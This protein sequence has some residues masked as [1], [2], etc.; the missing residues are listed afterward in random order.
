MASDTFFYSPN[1]LAA[2]FENKVR[3]KW[4]AVTP[5][6]D[7]GSIFSA[8]VE[9]YYVYESGSLEWKCPVCHYEYDNNHPAT[10]SRCHFYSGSPSYPGYD[11]TWS[12]YGYVTRSF[13][14]G[15]EYTALDQ[16]GKNNKFYV[17]TYGSYCDGVPGDWW[18]EET[19]WSAPTV[20]F[21]S[22]TG[23]YIS[24]DGSQLSTL[25][26]ARLVEGESNYLSYADAISLRNLTYNPNLNKFSKI[27]PGY[28]VKPYQDRTTSGQHLFDIGGYSDPSWHISG[29]NGYSG[30]TLK[31]A[32]LKSFRGYTNAYEYGC[33]GS[34]FYFPWGKLVFNSGDNLNVHRGIIYEGTISGSFTMYFYGTY[35]GSFTDGTIDEYHYRRIRDGVYVKNPDS[36]YQL[37]S[38]LAISSLAYPGLIV[39][40]GQH[41]SIAW[42]RNNINLQDRDLGDEDTGQVVVAT[43]SLN[44]VNTLSSTLLK[45][46][47]IYPAIF[48]NPD[49]TPGWHTVSKASTAKLASQIF[50]VDD[51]HLRVASSLT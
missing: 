38:T 48:Y 1:V 7:S 34:I 30:S 41:N 28:D 13:V 16:V 25:S 40:N 33:S 23:S 19:G 20:V 49:T 15:T 17:A 45:G 35:A 11:W 4:G 42:Y 51:C 18:F 37:Y 22:N 46:S 12:M 39:I 44:S 47:R 43:G 26:T 2:P 3:L 9:G 10:C 24:T 29:S 31:S 8:S 21:A 14:T 27:L 6:P 36:S 50:T 32:S 5:P